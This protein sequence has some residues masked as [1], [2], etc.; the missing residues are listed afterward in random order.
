MVPLLG[1]RIGRWGETGRSKTRNDSFGE[2]RRGEIA[3]HAQ[4]LP[5]P[6][7]M[8]KAGR[9]AVLAW[10]QAPTTSVAAATL[11]PAP[12]FGSERGAGIGPSCLT[13]R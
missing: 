8:H 10:L 11:S 1:N 2:D 6:F 12:L 9:G 3:R 13:V 5:L 7:L 4:N